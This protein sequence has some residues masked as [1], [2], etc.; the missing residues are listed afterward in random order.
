MLSSLDVDEAGLVEYERH[1][2]TILKE[3]FNGGPVGIETLS[4]LL[5]EE[6]ENVEEIYESY[7]LQIGFIERTKRGRTITKKGLNH[8]NGLKN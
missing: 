2:L 4:A 7:L 1:Y 3:R 6:K 8:L 5:D